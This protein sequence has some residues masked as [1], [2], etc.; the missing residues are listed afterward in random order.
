MPYDRLCGNHMDYLV[1]FSRQPCGEAVYGWVAMNLLCTMRGRLFLPAIFPTISQL[2]AAGAF[3][4]RKDE[5]EKGCESDE[6]SR[7]CG[8]ATPPASNHSRV[9]QASGANVLNIL[10]SLTCTNLVGTRMT[11]LAPQGSSTAKTT[12][13]LFLPILGQVLRK[14]LQRDCLSIQSLRI[15]TSAQCTK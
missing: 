6:V 10:I 5:H 9:E 4:R 3:P 12:H 11:Q 13:L 15:P 8:T 14:Q 1:L 2:Q 7:W